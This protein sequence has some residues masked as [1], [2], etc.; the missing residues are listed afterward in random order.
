MSVFHNNALIG[1]GGGA[2]A[3]AGATGQIKSLRFNDGDSASLSKTFSS[4][5]NRK[6]FTFS[7]WV[8]RSKLGD[9]QTI[10]SAGNSSPSQR[11]GIRF[12]NTDQFEVTEDSLDFHLETTRLFR[13]PGAWYHIVVAVDTTQAT[14]SNRIKVY[15]NGLQETA[16]DSA[17]YPSQNFDCIINSGDP[18]RIGELSFAGN[19]YEFGGYLADIYFIDGSAL[20]P[21]SFGA[22]DDSGKL[23]PTAEHMERTDS[24]CW[25][26]LM[27]QQ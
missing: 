13:D 8:K 10:L 25:I 2:A 9:W 20:D 12:Q 15:V 7:F 14:A 11:G 26:L 27:S 22:F 18:H 1:S 23:P 17:T 3:A 5:G 24:I 19:I 16:F 6:T 4:A 21:T